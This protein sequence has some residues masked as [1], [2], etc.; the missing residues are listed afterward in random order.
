LLGDL[1]IRQAPSSEGRNFALADRQVVVVITQ[2]KCGSTNAFAP[3]DQGLGV[4]RRCSRTRP[5]SRGAM[6]GGSRCS[7]FSCVETATERG[8][9]GGRCIER[10]GIAAHQPPR[11]HGHR[12]HQSPIDGPSQIAQPI[13]R[14]PGLTEPGQ[15]ME[16][17]RLYCPVLPACRGLRPILDVSDSSRLFPS[18][19]A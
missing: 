17:K 18:S 16:R 1:L 7:G 5:T 12:A 8:E 4:I 14:F 3:A 11:V 2:C 10:V 19:H 15:V 13:H 9:R 6:G